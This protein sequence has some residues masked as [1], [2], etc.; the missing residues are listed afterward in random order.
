MS[1]HRES[2]FTLTELA[3]VLV[4]VALLI[5]GLLL[6]LSAQ[7][8]AR[9]VSDTQRQLKEAR[10]ALLGFVVAKGYFPCPADAASNGQETGGRTLDQCNNRVGLLPWATLGIT[11]LDSWGRQLHYSVPKKLTDNSKT[12]NPAFALTDS[13]DIT[14][15]GENG[16]NLTSAGTVAAVI[17]SHGKN[18]IGGTTET[19]STIPNTSATNADEQENAGIAGTGIVF[20]ERIPTDNVAVSGGE[21][22]DILTWIPTYALMQQLVT[23]RRLP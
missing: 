15:K 5:G 4:I 7:Y 22:D 12:P 2:G 6:P 10:D 8:D 18:G 13:G 3:V 1:V 17:L 21:I 19:G 16:T 23:A 9:Y 14:I 11:R 20:H